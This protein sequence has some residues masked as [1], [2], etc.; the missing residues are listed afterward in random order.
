MFFGLQSPVLHRRRSGRLSQLHDEV[1]AILAFLLT[2][3]V[4]EGMVTL[5]HGQPA[6]LAALRVCGWSPSVIARS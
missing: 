4:I 5:A 1:A 6:G 3:G 2:V